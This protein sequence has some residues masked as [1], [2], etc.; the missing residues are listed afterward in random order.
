MMKYKKL[1]SILYILLIATLVTADVVL[2]WYAVEDWELEVCSK[3]GGT[4]EAQSGA[5]YS[6]PIFLSQ[7]TLSLQAKKET[8]DQIENASSLYK[9]SWYLEPIEDINYQVLLRGNES[10]ITIAEGEVTYDQ[11]AQGYY[12]A[13]HNNSYTKIRMIYGGE[14]IELDVVE[15]NQ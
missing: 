2:D 15:I 10:P 8:Y 5:S 7:T 14:W 12:A 3:W 13:Y 6:S 11:P 9:V 1:L 4:E